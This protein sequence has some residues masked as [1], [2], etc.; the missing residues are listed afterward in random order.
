VEFE[1]S[2]G[3]HLFLDRGCIKIAEHAG[4]I[5]PLRNGPGGTVDAIVLSFRV[6]RAN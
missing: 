1:L 2:G 5:Q 6:R 4:F 3:A